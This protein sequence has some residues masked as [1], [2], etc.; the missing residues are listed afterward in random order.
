MLAAFQQSDS[1][2]RLVQSPGCLAVPFC[3]MS[4]A[5]PMH[6]LP[7]LLFPI[8]NKLSLLKH[9]NCLDEFDGWIG[10]SNLFYWPLEENVKDCF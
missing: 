5:I 3:E 6:P 7:L 8:L 9:H 4:C 10:Y 1:F 2:Q